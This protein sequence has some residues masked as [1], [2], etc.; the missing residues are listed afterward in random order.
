MT[1]YFL[2]TKGYDGEQLFVYFHIS[3]VQ[4]LNAAGH[5]A[6]DSQLSTGHSTTITTLCIDFQ[7]TVLTFRHSFGRL[8][9]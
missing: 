4:F 7:T 8:K 5:M 6:D 2:P 9:V 1:L 3:T